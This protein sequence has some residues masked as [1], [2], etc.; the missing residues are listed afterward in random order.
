MAYSVYYSPRTAKKFPSKGSKHKKTKRFF[1]AL[2]I[3]CIAGVLLQLYRSGVL[4]ELLIPGEPAVTVAAME[5]LARNI[6]EGM[7]FLQAAETFCVEIFRSA[8]FV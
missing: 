6:S 1:S 8:P 7:P 4:Y 2:L 5:M 3:I